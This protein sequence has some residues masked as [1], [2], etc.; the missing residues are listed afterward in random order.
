MFAGVELGGAVDERHMAIELTQPLT[1][2]EWMTCSPGLLTVRISSQFPSPLASGIYS[3]VYSAVPESFNVTG[4]GV[5]LSSMEPSPLLGVASG[6]GSS[7]VHAASTSAAT[8]SVDAVVMRRTRVVAFIT[9]T[10]SAAH[11]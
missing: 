3:A 4:S 10:N 5:T 11:P 9:Q 7:D 8:A 2:T 6:I 1:G